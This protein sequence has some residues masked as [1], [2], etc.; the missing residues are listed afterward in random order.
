LSDGLALP[1]EPV[2]EL[3]EVALGTVAAAPA[4]EAD[5]HVAARLRQALATDPRVNELHVSVVVSDRDVVVRGQVATPSRK[6]AIDTVLRGLPLP[7]V[8]VLG[9]H[10]YHMN[11]Q[12]AIRTVLEEAGVRVLEGE[13]VVVAVDGVR[14][15]VAGVKGFGGGFAGACATEFGEP[16]MK[17]F[18]ASG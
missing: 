6:R 7:V 1:A 8:A 15:G 14:V 5:H 2:R 10:D 11:A 17:T 3:F 18:A 9:N 4:A 16:E 12:D 13:G